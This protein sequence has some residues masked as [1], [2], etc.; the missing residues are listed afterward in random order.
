MGRTIRFYV[1]RINDET[2]DHDTTKK[3]CF[4]LEREP[5]DKDEF[6]DL[7]FDRLKNESHIVNNIHNV[8]LPYEKYLI[9]KLSRYEYD[10]M[11]YEI[12]NILY[13]EYMNDDEDDD[14]DDECERSGS[15]RVDDSKYIKNLWCP[16]CEV[17]AKGGFT[18][19]TH[20]KFLLDYKEISHSYSNPIW[21]SKY[22]VWDLQ[23]GSKWHTEFI[24]LFDHD[25]YDRCYR[26]VEYRDVEYGRLYLEKLGV[27]ILEDESNYDNDKCKDDDH[28]GNGSEDCDTEDEYDVRVSKEIDM[29]AYEETVM[30]LDFIEMW[31][32]KN[33]KDN[34]SIKVIVEDE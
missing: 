14:K 30:I 33:E 18:K 27:P 34:N 5:K 28:D 26:E 12:K 7:F 11:T 22:N 16:K 32:S 3:L 8:I 15:G 4:Q 17:L 2:F 29:E 6:K 19:N 23:L 31:L 9:R 13:M 25:R 20:K 24:K 1:V 21:Y 10:N